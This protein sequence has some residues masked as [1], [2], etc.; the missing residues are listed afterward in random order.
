LPKHSEFP[1]EMGWTVFIVECADGTYSTGF[2][3]NLK[4][5]IASINVFQ[6]GYYFSRHP[7]RVPV[8]VVFKETNLPFKEAFSK[9]RYLKNMPRKNKIRLIEKGIWPIGG[10]YREYLRT[11][12]ASPKYRGKN[13][14]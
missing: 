13:G 2:C 9:A 1:P 14:L 7:E 12:R 6:E 11:N 10:A 4:K 5:K 8:K 3:S